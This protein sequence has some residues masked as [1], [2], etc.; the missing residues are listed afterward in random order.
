MTNPFSY[1]GKRVVVTGAA[2]AFL[3]T[4]ASIY[5]NGVNLLVDAGF[6]AAMTANQVDFSALSA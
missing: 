3:G 4:E 6:T 1:A 2:I 5:V